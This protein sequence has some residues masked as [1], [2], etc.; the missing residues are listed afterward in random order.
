[1]WKIWCLLL[2]IIINITVERQKIKLDWLH[3]ALNLISPTDVKHLQCDVI[4]VDLK[5]V[6]W[7]WVCVVFFFL[8]QPCCFFVYLIHFYLHF[9]VP[10][11]PQVPLEGMAKMEIRSLVNLLTVF[12]HFIIHV[13]FSQIIIII[14]LV[15]LLPIRVLEE[16][17]V[18]LDQQGQ[19]WEYLFSVLFSCSIKH[20]FCLQCM[21]AR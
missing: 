14:L 10:L 9:R 5:P 21:R 17:M 18:N 20:R 11:G 6:S 16:K 8:G 3:L 15:V 2:P 13:I 7:D 4:S 1:M 12:F 19:R